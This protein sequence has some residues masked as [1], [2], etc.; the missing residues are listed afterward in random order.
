M[1]SVSRQ[2]LR[3]LGWLRQVRAAIALI[4]SAAAGWT[5]AWAVLLI[6]QGV[7]PA[8][9][10][11]ITKW[12]VDSV[13]AAVGA[14]VTAEATS[15]VILP[16]AVMGGLLLLQ[17][18]LSS[19]EEWVSTG[20]AEYIGDHI[21]NVIHAKA[22]SVDYAFYE[23]AG[24][25]DLLEQANAQ[26]SGRVLQLLQ[27][28]GTLV[29]SGI[30]FAT[31]A[32]L[33]IVYSPWIP[34]LLVVGAAPAFAIVLRHNRI[35]HAW[36]VNATP[37]RR[38]A[39]YYDQILTLGDAAAEVRMGRFGDRFRSQYQSLRGALRNERLNLLQRQILARLLAA[40]IALVLAGGVMAWIVWRALDGAA[41]LGDL[42]LFYGAFTQGQALVGSIL[43]NVGAV[44]TNALFLEHLHKFL[45]LENE[46]QDPP[47]PVPVP[48]VIREGICFDDVTFTY[49]DATRPALKNFSLQIPAGRTVAIV[50]ENGAGKSTFIKLLCRFYDPDAGTVTLDGIHLR[51]FSQDDLRRR[52]S[53]LFQ[54]PM[55]Y[56]MTAAENIRM[57]DVDAPAD[58]AAL[59]N[60][61]RGAD[62]EAIVDRLP[63][64][65]DTLLGRWFAGGT[66]LS[67]GEWQRMSLARAFFR[68]APFVILDEPTSFMDSWAENE[69]LSR[70]QAMAAGR[71]ALII[72]HR[73]TTA[74]RADTIHVIERGRIVESGTHDELVALGGRYASSW[75][76]QVEQTGLDSFGEKKAGIT[77]HPLVA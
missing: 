34:L 25:H 37:R 6:V 32:A 21:K 66:E 68:K 23:S 54:F 48:N 35:Y 67:G 64:G 7:L 18:I 71:T 1:S 60:A 61:A 50:G 20:Q 26:S 17:R 33:L 65:F 38:L 73:F 77:T 28:G 9:I 2:L 47:V 15:S 43:Q 31:I 5:I 4:W 41:T 11:A 19:L 63:N 22:A 27:N 70:F 76:A 30:T 62:A 72:T 53:V 39:Q 45:E 58:F 42:A 10:I 49:P 57:G 74:M 52:I 75:R 24:Y 46:M 55:K 3:R 13:A 29:R 59:S 51:D 16:A 56:Q 44:Y 36:W 12:L 69:W 40:V 8:A 14:G